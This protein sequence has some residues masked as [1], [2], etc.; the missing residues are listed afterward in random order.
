MIV[1]ACRSMVRYCYARF[2]VGYFDMSWATIWPPARS[3]LRDIF[4]AIAWFYAT[5]KLFFFDIDQMVLSVMAPSWAWL[6][7][8]RI[9]PILALLLLAVTIMGRKRFVLSLGYLIGF[10]FIVLFWKIPRRLFFVGN[11]VIS[12]AVINAFLSIFT[13]IPYR[14]AYFV[15]YCLCC[16]LVWTSTSWEIVIGSMVGLAV[17]VMASYVKAI[18]DAFRQPKVLSLYKWI[19]ETVG[20]RKAV[21][22]VQVPAIRVKIA[23]LIPKEHS[24]ELN[25]LQGEVILSQLCSFLANKLREYNDS[26]VHVLGGIVAVMRLIAV[27]WITYAILYYA[28]SKIDANAFMTPVPTAWF[29]FVYVSFDNMLFNMNSSSEVSS[30][31]TKFLSMSQ[32]FLSALIGLILLVVLFEVRKKKHSREIEEAA[33]AAERASAVSAKAVT[34]QFD[35]TSLE[36]AV[37]DLQ[38][39][40]S[41]LYAALLK[42]LGYLQRR[43]A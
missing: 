24:D 1:S 23:G 8:L 20:K 2:L 19:F 6:L 16:V 18:I 22:D 35:Y 10:P 39:A 37:A 32:R 7:N 9:V 40:E 31:I 33:K 34:T 36:E 3:L 43:G 15:T 29:D 11:W 14:L 17:C 27:M 25:K 5:T 38:Q 28:A 4:C 13:D 21:S 42:L 26:E 12:L 30:S 41:S